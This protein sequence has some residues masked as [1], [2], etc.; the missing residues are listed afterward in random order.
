[1]TYHFE[2]V[3]EGDFWSEPLTD[4]ASNPGGGWSLSVGC[5]SRLAL[6]VCRFFVSVRVFVLRIRRM[7]CGYR[8]LFLC[9]RF[10]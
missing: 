6:V 7:L 9:R 4:G 5:W 3:L 8:R 10:L 2:T 1:M